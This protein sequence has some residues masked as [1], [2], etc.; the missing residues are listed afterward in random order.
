MINPRNFI[1]Y[2]VMAKTFE[3]LRDKHGY[4]KK[5]VGDRVGISNSTVA[6][7][8]F[9]RSIP[10]LYTIAKYCSLYKITLVEFFHLVSITNDK[11]TSPIITSDI[12]KDALRLMITN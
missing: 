9:G 8:E 12:R 3:L 5:Y 4:T 2:D 10:D 7:H 6:N 11:T 1:R